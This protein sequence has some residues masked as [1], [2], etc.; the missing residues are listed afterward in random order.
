MTTGGRVRPI[1]IVTPLMRFSKAQTVKAAYAIPDCWSALAYS[2]T[3][4]DGLYPPTGMNHANILRA[5]G[6]LKADLPDPLVIR[7]F[8]EGLMRLPDTANYRKQRVEETMNIL[9]Y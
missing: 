1:K 6:F 9:G 5:N 4:Y 3:S 2:H 8:C 7:A